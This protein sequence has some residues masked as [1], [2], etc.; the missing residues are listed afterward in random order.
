M[1]NLD[2]F[3]LNWIVNF[4]GLKSKD[5]VYAPMNDFFY[6]VIKLSSTMES[7]L[8]GI[9]L[10]HKLSFENKTMKLTEKYIIYWGQFNAHMLPKVL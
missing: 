1:A 3:V 4:N 8:R 7:V 9:I 10:Q 2:V 6:S 5:I